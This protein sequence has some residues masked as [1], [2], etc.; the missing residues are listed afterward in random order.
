MRGLGKAAGLWAVVGVLLAGVLGAVGSG[1]AALTTYRDPDGTQVFRIVSPEITESS[2]LAVSTVDPGLVYTTNDSGDAAT[3]YVLDASNGAVVGH[4]RLAGVEARDIEAISAGTDGTLVV[5]DI[6]DNR[7]ERDEVS[8]YQVEQLGRGDHTVTPRRLGLTYADGPRDAEAT[9][10]DARTGRVYVV[11]KEI[12]GAAVFA[13]PRNVFEREEAVLKPVADAPAI[14]TDATLLPGG[15][16]AIIRTYGKAYLYAF[17]AFGPR[18]MIELPSIGQGESVTAPASGKVFWIG[19]E[20]E[21]SPVV[22]LPLPGRS[23]TPDPDTTPP[24]SP[25][26]T[27]P[28]ASPGASTNR[29]NDADGDEGLEG[30]AQTVLLA[31]G[32]GL[33]VL[34]LVVLVVSVVSRRRRARR[35]ALPEPVSQQGN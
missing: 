15:D 24:S 35:A 7:A 6:G 1:V 33:V 4:I 10:Y 25:G 27:N 5:A 2:S 19:A 14:A 18:R 31:A 21:D 11:S 30:I 3:V 20:G 16:R 22:A 9:M 32:A 26:A 34:V 17:P 29:G 28:Q 23:T 12:V 8:I 13:T